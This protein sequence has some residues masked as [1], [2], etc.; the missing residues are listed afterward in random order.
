LSLTLE[1]GKRYALV[2]AN[3]CGKTTI[4]RLLTGLYPAESGCIWVN[5]R[6]LRE[7][8]ARNCAASF[9]R[10]PGFRPI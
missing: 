1:A 4:T 6:D 3:G 2:G 5:G 10:L 9:G 7:V 8:T